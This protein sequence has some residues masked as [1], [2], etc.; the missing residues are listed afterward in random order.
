MTETISAAP[1][2]VRSDLH[3]TQ[4]LLDGAWVDADSG[5]TIAVTNP[6]TGEEVAHVPKHGR[7]G[8]APGD[9]GRAARA[10]G[11]A[12]PSCEGAGAD[13]A[14][15]GGP[16][17]RER[18]GPRA[19]AHARAGEAA[20][21]VADRD[22]LRGLVLR[23]VRRGGEARLRRHDSR[24]RDRPADHRP[25]AAGRCHRRDHAVELPVGDDHAQVRAR[26][27]GRVHD[28]AEAGIADAALRARDRG[29]R[30]GGGHPRRRLLASSP[31]RP[32]R[33]ARR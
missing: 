22:R 1:G 32:R 5:E 11:L 12:Q 3:R 13:P 29:A 16:D 25:Q 26:A 33:S 9:R 23:V 2:L 18:R 4:T 14:P 17:A 6:A 24:A 8:D 20:R 31:A 30:R 28:G 15:L 19:A 27:R 21:R 10:S 7:R